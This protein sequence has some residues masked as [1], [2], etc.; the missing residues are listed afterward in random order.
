MN[1]H[2]VKVLGSATLLQLAFLDHLIS[3]YQRFKL[4]GILIGDSAHN[5]S[6]IFTLTVGTA[7]VF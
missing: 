6:W 5:P 7:T 2:F 1:A 4:L 3:L